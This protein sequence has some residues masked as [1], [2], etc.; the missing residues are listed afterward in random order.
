MAAA[1]TGMALHGGV[2]PYGATFLSFSDYMRPSIRL[3]ALSKAHVIYIWTHD[4]IALGE[5]G[6]THQPVE[7]L[8]GLRS[9]PNMLTLR[10]CDAT[11]TVE[12][13]RIALQHRDGPVGLVLTRQK[14]PVLDRNMVAPASGLAR[15]G[16]VLVDAGT[17]SL[18]IIMIASGSEVSL[19]LS[20][21]EQLT[22]AGIGSRVVSMPSWELFDREPQ[23]YRDDVL[24][25][26]VRARIAIEAASPFGWERYVGS[27]G[28]IV[29][30]NSFGASA[31]G[32]VVMREFGFTPEHVVEIA[33][34]VL[35][36]CR[37]SPNLTRTG[38]GQPPRPVAARV[39]TEE[40]R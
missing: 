39:A 31:P 1:L 3:A 35:E 38:L 7:H 2:I 19:A 37:R 9:I 6:P 28:A 21:H 20:A 40:R 27:D 32:P 23:H 18:D 15:G 17:L 26:A 5:D 13:W 30:V 10:P 34:Q 33:M 25:P 36:R 22:N 4:S 24:P 11:E 14:L 8:A 12:A 29:G 16:Y